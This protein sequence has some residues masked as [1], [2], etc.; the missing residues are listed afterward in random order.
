MSGGITVGPISAYG[1]RT[2]SACPP[3]NPPAVCEYPKIPPTAVA[4]GLDSWQFPY[5][6]C[7][8]K[9]HFPQAMLNG[10]STLS[11]IFKFCTEDPTSTTSPQNSC[12][13]VLPTR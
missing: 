7:L 9:A 12:P 2:Y 6:P 13:K 10:T 4:S 3:S 5:S 8:Q 11:P 1:T